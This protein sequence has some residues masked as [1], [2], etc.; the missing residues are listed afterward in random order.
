M[1]QMKSMDKIYFFSDKCL[2]SSTVLLITI[3]NISKLK[4][5]IYLYITLYL[6]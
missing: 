2:I 1:I 6:K 4:R 3:V 5:V